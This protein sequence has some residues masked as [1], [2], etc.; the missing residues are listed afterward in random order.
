MAGSGDGGLRC[1]PGSISGMK[2]SVSMDEEDVDFL[3]AYA[4]A[5]GVPS[6]SGVVQRAIALL[7]SSEL[8]QD[9]AA[10]WSE[11]DE[12]EAALWDLATTDGLGPAV[13]DAAG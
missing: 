3:D 8:G 10:A 1:Y 12:D 11:W 4:S 5:H 7:R 9:Y 13:A 6:R 2:L